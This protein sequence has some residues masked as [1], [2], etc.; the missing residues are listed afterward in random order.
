MHVKSAL[1]ALV[2]L[3]V[4]VEGSL[5]HNSPGS[6]T[7]LRRQNR[8]GGANRGGNNG[9][10]GGNNGGNNG[11]GNAANT[12]LQ[13]N[14]VQTGSASTGQNGAVAADGQVNSET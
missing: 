1:V 3:T 9:G 11:G 2:G 6:R 12:C 10:N 13:A 5:V 14:A 4:A 8:N 7:I